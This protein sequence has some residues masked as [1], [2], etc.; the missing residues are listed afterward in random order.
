MQMSPTAGVPDT[1]IDYA[2]DSMHV[3][4]CVAATR[5]RQTVLPL[6][7]LPLPFYHTYG[8]SRVDIDEFCDYFIEHL[9]LVPDAGMR[10]SS[11]E[12]HTKRCLVGHVK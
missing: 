6:L 7:I 10:T 4:V 9:D 11:D 8:A 5:C 2:W 3:S 12:V 1:H